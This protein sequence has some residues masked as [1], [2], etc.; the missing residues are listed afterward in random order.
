MDSFNLKKYLIEN[1][2]TQDS[3]SLS[4]ASEE[5]E[6]EEIINR[7]K[8]GELDF[9]ATIP[10]NPKLSDDVLKLLKKP[11]NSDLLSKIMNFNIKKKI[12]A[13]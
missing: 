4:E 1:K 5:F 3:K 10:S 7:I 13:K 11:E 9:L 8:N 2:L 12:Q 6:A